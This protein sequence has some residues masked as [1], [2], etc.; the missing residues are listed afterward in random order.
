[1]PQD[2]NEPTLARGMHANGLCLS[3]KPRTLFH[4]LGARQAPELVIQAHCLSPI[5]HRTM[6]IEL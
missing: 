5:S 3:D 2:S 4:I 1:M 6:R